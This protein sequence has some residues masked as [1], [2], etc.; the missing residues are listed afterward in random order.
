MFDLNTKY[1]KYPSFKSHTIIEFHGMKG[2]KNM[3]F[4]EIEMKTFPHMI[5]TVPLRWEWKHEPLYI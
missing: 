3:S 4:L 1:I 5:V 2:E